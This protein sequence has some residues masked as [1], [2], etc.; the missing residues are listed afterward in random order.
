[1]TAAWLHAL[2]C[3]ILDDEPFADTIKDSLIVTILEDGDRL[4]C[5][6]C[7]GIALL[8]STERICARVVFNR[9]L[10]IADTALAE[11]VQGN[12]EHNIHG[13]AAS[14]EKR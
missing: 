7:K 2:V 4:N 1:M 11:S 9:R 6:N 5:G 14:G 3:I 12:G 8:S 10:L 13:E